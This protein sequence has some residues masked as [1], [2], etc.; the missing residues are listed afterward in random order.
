MI[1]LWFILIMLG[2]VWL[3]YISLAEYKEH[4]RT[5]KW[6]RHNYKIEK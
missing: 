3:V 1:N 5:V 6:I 2:I 4:K